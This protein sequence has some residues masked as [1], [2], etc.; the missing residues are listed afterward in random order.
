RRADRITTALAFLT[1]FGLGAALSTPAAAQAHRAACEAELEQCVRA[2]DC[3]PGDLTCLIRCPQYSPCL[4]EFNAC[5]SSGGPRGGRPE[6]LEA[7]APPRASTA[8]RSARRAQNQEL[9]GKIYYLE[10]AAPEPPNAKYYG[11]LIVGVNVAADRKIAVMRG[12]GCRLAVVPTYDDAL[13][14]DN[15]GLVVIPSL[16]AASGTSTNPFE[17]INNYDA[18]RAGRWLEAV[19][20]AVGEE[21]DPREAILF[22]GSSTAQS[23]ALDARTMQAPTSDTTVVADASALNARY[24]ARWTDEVVRGVREGRVDSRQSMQGLMEYHS[25]LSVLGSPLAAVMKIT[26]AQAGEPP[27]DCL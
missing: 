18:V 23:Q 9:Q 8:T 26:P 1:A 24:L 16:R 14:I 22:V 25:W 7:P 21:F 19:G 17:M 20:R 12:L 15:L 6:A 3:Q 5:M 10:R 13:A 4:N 2:C 27:R 11:Y